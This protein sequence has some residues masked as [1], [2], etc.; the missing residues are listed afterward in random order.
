M[1]TLDASTLNINPASELTIY[2]VEE[3]TKLVQESFSNAKQ[4]LINL[5]Q[6]EKIDTAGFQLLISLQKSCSKTNKNFE[7]I[8]LNSSVENFLTLCGFSFETKENL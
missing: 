5:Q 3:I 1:V 4:V 6:T 8:E 7:I 2:Q